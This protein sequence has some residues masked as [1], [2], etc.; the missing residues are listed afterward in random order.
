MDRSSF[1]MTL[2][3]SAMNASH[4]R[5]VHVL[6]FQKLLNDQGYLSAPLICDTNPHTNYMAQKVI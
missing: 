5:W 1:R 4:F 6:L 2:H 3:S